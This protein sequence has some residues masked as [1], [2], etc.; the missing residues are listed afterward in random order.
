MFVVASPAECILMAVQLPHLK[1]KTADSRFR[2][3]AV[4]QQPF[5]LQLSVVAS[6]CVMASTLGGMSL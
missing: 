4:I 5:S 3:S 6:P 2:K 1:R